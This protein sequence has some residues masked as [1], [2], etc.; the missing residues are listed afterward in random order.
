MKELTDSFAKEWPSEWKEHWQEKEFEN[1]SPIQVKSFPPLFQGE[2][3]VVVSPTGSGKTLAYLFPTLLKVTK[4]SGNQLLI[5]LPSHEL[6]I[7]V[8]KVTKEW[9][10]LLGLHSETIIG[11]ANT[12][13]QLEKLKQQPEII[14]GSAGRIFEWIQN[15][16]IKAHLLQTII[17]D[18]VDQLLQTNEVTFT[19]KIMQRLDNKAQQIFV[20]ATALQNKELA[21]KLIGSDTQVID[22]TNEDQSNRQTTHCYVQ[23][24]KRKKADYLRRLAHIPNMSA[25]VFFNELT[26]MGSIAEKLAYEGVPV[27]T[28]ASDQSKGE[29]KLALQLFEK[30][31]VRLLLTTDIAA[32]GLDFEALPYVIQYDLPYKAENYRHRSGRTG[33]MGK[34]GVVLS[35]CEESQKRDIRK[36][37]EEMKEK[38]VEVFI[39]GGAIVFEKPEILAEKSSSIPETKEKSLLVK[40]KVKEKVKKSKKKSKVKKKAQKDKGARKKS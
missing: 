18:E 4:G 25:V 14:V 33:R 20:S 38:F 3:A 31:K 11:G 26:E 28:L 39:H 35:L 36:F 37:E 1:F 34:K 23:I 32:R 12:K 16:K 6:A 27:V 13:R 30:G 17:L 15:K 9:A 5:L 21:Q 24:P 10:D 40:K 19:Q 2:N 29:R 8:G 22:V 7:Q